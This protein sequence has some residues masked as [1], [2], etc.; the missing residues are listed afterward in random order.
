M[1]ATLLP[2]YDN[3]FGNI[4]QQIATV[5]QQNMR[6]SGFKQYEGILYFGP[7]GPYKGK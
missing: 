5:E 4:W 3:T 2:T 1:I 7:L 6:F